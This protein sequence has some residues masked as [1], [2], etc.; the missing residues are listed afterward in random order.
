MGALSPLKIPNQIL[1]SDPRKI[2]KNDIREGVI[3]ASNG[4][5][6]L[7][8]GTDHSIP[9]HWKKEIGKRIIVKIKD[10]FPNF[11]VYEI[12]K[13]QL[14]NFWSYNVK[15]GGNLFSLLTE[16][17]GPKI[18]TSRKSIKINESKWKST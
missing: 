10:G 4:K 9:Y 15:H 6:F 5:K 14:P 2:K 8:I 11:T 7:D 3:I 12:E 1:T 17:I 18:L 16:W 13:N